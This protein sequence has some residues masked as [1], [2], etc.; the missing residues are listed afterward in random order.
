MKD[1][2]SKN[3]VTTLITFILIPTVFLAGSGTNKAHSGDELL[4]DEQLQ[5]VTPSPTTSLESTLTAT[6][7]PDATQAAIQAT[8]PTKSSQITS[9]ISGTI[10][11]WHSWTD[12][13]LAGLEQAISDFQLKYPKIG[14][15]LRYVP[16][17]DLPDRFV[18]EMDSGKPDLLI[19]S[20]GWGAEL[21]DSGLIADVS[22]IADS[23]F[24]EKIGEGALKTAQYNNALIGLPVAYNQGIVIFRNRSIMPEASKTFDDYLEAAIDVTR[25]DIV[26]A[27]IDLGFFQSGGYLNACGGTLM[28]TRGY[29]LFNNA[30]GLC[31]IEIIKKIQ[32][33]GLPVDFN[34]DLDLE[35]FKTGKIGYIVAGTWDSSSLAEAIG[36]E[37]LAVDPWPSMEDG[38]LS[39]FMATDIIYLSQN[40]A[41]ENQVASNA[42]IRY[43]LSTSAQQALADP[44]TARILPIL[45]GIE[46]RDRLMQETIIALDSGTPLPAIPAMAYYWEPLNKALR[47]ILF[48]GEDPG[49]ALENAAIRIR[50]RIKDLQ[51]ER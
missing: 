40:V 19:G 32:E 24:F 20:S 25:G 14:I 17:D 3:F 8:T 49:Q 39:G 37:N 22:K 9:N 28:D 45:K 4:L 48:D 30:T 16:Y 38:Q 1:L 34:T 15:D 31:W 18:S 13:K 10:T 51:L 50:I 27:V 42:L 2:V 47:S 11:L 26:G 35:R 44:S 41:P 46:S 33:T 7:S 5:Q 21:Y 23:K 36:M 29:P 43:L 12:N 6:P